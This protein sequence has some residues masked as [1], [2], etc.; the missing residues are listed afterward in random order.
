[1]SMKGAIGKMLLDDEQLRKL[2]GR[3]IRAVKADQK[4]ATKDFAYLVY[5][6]P[7][8][9][10]FHHLRGH[11]GIIKPDIVVDCYGKTGPIASKIAERVKFIFDTMRNREIEEVQI[12][13]INAMGE[14]LTYE[15][16]QNADDK[17]KHRHSVTFES[18]M[19]TT[20]PE[21]A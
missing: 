1:M 20:K 18:A 8:I 5:Q 3:R 13:Y 4:D 12:R 10:N 17:G 16:A 9:E 14:F 2:V 21:P 15:A 7:N 11:S 19:H 6:T